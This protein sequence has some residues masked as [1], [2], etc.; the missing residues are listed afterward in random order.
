MAENKGKEQVN[1]LCFILCMLGNFACFLVSAL[2]ICFK[3]LFQK[4]FVEIPLEC[5]K[6][7]RPNLGR[8]CFKR[9]SA[10]YQN[11]PQA[12][13]LKTSDFSF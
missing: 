6:I 5:Q 2:C 1:H 9:L 3:L 8:H 10:K 7:I 4:H 12:R 13:K 11:M